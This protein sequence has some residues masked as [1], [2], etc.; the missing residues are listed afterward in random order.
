MTDKNCF[1]ATEY[2]KVLDVSGKDACLIEI[3]WVKDN[4]FVLDCWHIVN[5]FGKRSGQHECS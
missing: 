1:H 2:G 3:R 4:D 5:R